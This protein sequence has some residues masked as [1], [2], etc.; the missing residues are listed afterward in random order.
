VERLIHK[1]EQ[2]VRKKRERRV[3]DRAFK[4]EAVQMVAEQGL[5]I[6][7]VARKLNI[8][9]NMLSRWKHEHLKSKKQAFTGIKHEKREEEL[10]Q[11]RREVIALREEK[12]IMKKALVI[13]SRGTKY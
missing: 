9:P 6:S 5:R 13:L 11:L 3:F 7:H 2:N 8:H 10:K 12:E 4:T 1:E